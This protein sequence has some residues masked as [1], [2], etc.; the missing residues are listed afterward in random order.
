MTRLIRR[1]TGAVVLGGLALFVDVIAGGRVASA[2]DRYLGA[3][4]YEGYGPIEEQLNVND[5]PIPEPIGPRFLRDNIPGLGETMQRWPAFFRDTSLDLHIRSFYF[6]RELP[7]RPRPPTG[8]AT[9]PRRRG[10]WAAGS[11]MQSGWLLDT[12]RMGAVGYTSQPAYAP[13]DRDGTGL[14][15]PGQEGHHGARP[16]V[17]SAPLQGLRGPHGRPVPRRSGLR[18][19][20][21][22]PHDPE[23]VRGRH[24]DGH[25]RPRGVLRRLPDRDEAA[26]PRHLRQHGRGRR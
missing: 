9:S 24:P 13:D 23:H 17:G 3:E 1:R 12:F 10:R 5:P 21:G 26:E 25:D 11:A 8:P 6:N 4:H 15:A 20:A 18:Q 16:G 22:Q 7:I 2:D 14:L 19:P